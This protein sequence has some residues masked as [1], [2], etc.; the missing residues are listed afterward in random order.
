MNNN[1]GMA[2]D[3]RSTTAG[4]PANQNNTEASTP[5]F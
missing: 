4:R 5:G 2:F 3:K 1:Y